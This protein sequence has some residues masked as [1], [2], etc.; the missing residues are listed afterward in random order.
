[1]K[2]YEELTELIGGTPLLKLNHLMEKE[3]L[4]TNLF[5]KLEFFNPGGSVKDRIALSMILDA[6]EKGLLA[7][8]GTIIEPTSGN[9]G[10]GLALV[11]TLRGYHLILTMPETMSIE[12]RSL[13]KAFGAE[14]V[15]TD[16]D[17][18]MQGSIDKAR[19]LNQKIPNSIILEQFE[20]PAN[21]IAHEKTTAVE[22]L[23]D[24]DGS[25]DIFVAGVGT[26]GTLGGVGKG[27][28]EKNP[29]VQII[30]VEPWSSQVLKGEPAGFHAI[31]GIGA[32]FVPAVLD[33]D[34]IDEIIPV[35]DEDAYAYARVLTKT[36]GLLVGISSGA[37]VW[38]A[39]ELA[40][41]PENAK[42]N[43]V[44]LMPDTGERY[45][46]TPLFN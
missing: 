30:A 18:A 37:A 34:I 45:L 11:A 9:T 46:S 26:G 33:L 7:P 6:E 3:A 4:E 12:R 38:A 2:V 1:M 22:I 31:Q 13:L 43:I 16:G 35:K 42:K 10:I 44:V 24:L 23:D 39:I 29:D 14:I 25:V 27:L 36:E 20:N 17:M 32:N 40:R 15:L 21:P 19:E 5:G 8:G 28:K 41:R